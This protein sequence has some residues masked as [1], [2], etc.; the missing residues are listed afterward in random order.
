[1]NYLNTSH[2]G[3]GCALWLAV[4]A[5]P[6]SADSIAEQRPSVQA[7]PDTS[8]LVVHLPDPGGLRA[9]LERHTMLGELLFGPDQQARIETFLDTCMNDKAGESG[10]RRYGLE[11]SDWPELFNGPSGAALVLARGA[12]GHGGEQTKFMILAWIEPGEELAGRLTNAA[13]M[14]FTK[15]TSAGSTPAATRV[16]M[17]LAGHQVTRLTL[18]VMGLRADLDTIPTPDNYRHLSQAEREAYFA[19]WQQMQKSRVPEEINRHYCFFTRMGSRILLGF[20]P[21]QGGDIKYTVK[22]NVDARTHRDD[23]DMDAAA[24]IEPLTDKFGHF[25]AAH[26]ATRT[27]E[28][29]GHI[30]EM[31]DIGSELPSN[32]A[33]CV[34]IY[35]DLRRLR[36]QVVKGNF[37]QLLEAWLQRF[38]LDQ[39][40][41]LFWR[42]VL[43]GNILRSGAFLS[44]PAPR[45]GV[46]TCLD[47]PP[48]ESEPA[49]WVPVGITEYL[50][51]N[52]DLQLLYNRIKSIAIDVLGREAVNEMESHLAQGLGVDLFSILRAV[53]Q[54]HSFVRYT[55]GNTE[56]R[57]AVRH[58]E[59][60]V[61]TGLDEVEQQWAWVWETADAMLSP[62][63]VQSL[64]AWFSSDPEAAPHRVEEQGFTGWRASWAGIPTALFAGKGYM[65]FC[66]GA[67]AVSRH[68]NA[69]SQPSIHGALLL[70]NGPMMQQARQMMPLEPGIGFLIAD[71]DKIMRDRLAYWRAGTATAPMDHADNPVPS[72]LKSQSG[73]ASYIKTPVAS[74]FPPDAQIAKVFG[75]LVGT[76]H[77]NT[78]GLWGRSALWLHP[79]S[80]PRGTRDR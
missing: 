58:T 5:A 28:L 79:A 67:D 47:Q 68:L 78:R 7:L 22:H 23:V 19:R 48:L 43:D 57:H 54:R 59:G 32:G 8:V 73:F 65:T 1:M 51:V 2:Y 69:L 76:V 12:D 70:R 21:A 34:E 16:D 18:P 31:H 42:T 35:V 11:G 61:A 29:P 56:Y 24:L 26:D 62:Q 33:A 75:T 44:L 46:L 80:N 4:V 13:E 37:G 72:M 30:A 6:A 50:H 60:V 20:V 52:L 77:T 39:I 66:Y 64:V 15:W 55:T 38:G 71:Y 14:L 53:S 25:L 36:T 41:P 17:E 63:I 40:G 10:I 3:I 9:T 27:E 45:V 49:V 74:L